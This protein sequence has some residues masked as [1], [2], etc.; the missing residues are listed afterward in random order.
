MGF[1][2]GTPPKTR[3]EAVFMALGAASVAW[4]NPGGAG[5]FDSTLCK[6]IGDALLEWLKE[7]ET[8]GV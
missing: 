2:F 5:V 7:E 8:S 6:Q 3:E 1:E 4:E